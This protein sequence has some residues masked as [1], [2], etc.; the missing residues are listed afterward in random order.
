M[1]LAPPALAL[2]LAPA[3]PSCC[4]ILEL[5][6]YTLHPGQRDVLI[7]LFDREFVETQEAFGMRI[8]GQFRDLDRPDRFV[9]LRGFPDMEVRARALTGF[10]GGPVW[11][12]NSKAANATMIDSS[13][14]LLLHP[15]RPESGFALDAVRRPEPGAT[16]GPRA[17]VVATVYSFDA[18]PSP[19]LLDFFERELQPAL[20]AAGAA[21]LGR[22]VSESS[23]NTFP[24]LPVREGEHV[25]VLFARFESAAAYDGHLTAL[26]RSKRWSAVSQSLSRRLARPPVTLRLAPTARSLVGS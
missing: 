14:V 15:A 26:A 16:G 3:P 12:A 1:L 5:R 24:A 25:F 4:P 19:E 8:V 18:G 23:P 2:L 10:Y 11:K 21:V 17:L 20:E 7:E 13:D 22:F 6:Q 9:W